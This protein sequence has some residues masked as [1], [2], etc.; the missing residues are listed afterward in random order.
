MGLSQ[1]DNAVRPRVIVTVAYAPLEG[2]G[3]LNGHKGLLLLMSVL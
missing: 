2:C 1:I 3:C